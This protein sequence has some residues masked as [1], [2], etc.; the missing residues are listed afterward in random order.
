MAKPTIKQKVYELIYE[1]I[2]ERKWPE[3]EIL[4]EGYLASKYEVS[5]APIREA[6]IELC[7]DNV[8]RNIPRTGYQVVSIS[9]KEVLEVLE[10]RLDLELMLLRKGFEKINNEKLEE[11]KKY[12]QPAPQDKRVMTNWNQNQS[13]HLALCNLYDNRSAY[14]VLQEL[15]RKCSRYIARYFYSAWDKS[16]ESNSSYHIAIA[17]AL[18]HGDLELACSMLEE[19]IMAVKKELRELF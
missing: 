9:L 19:D 16:R 18:E 8:L 13:F 10:F 5:R 2:I 6:L 3:N 15:L 1:S 12:A 11:I 4:T 7:K 14:L 17:E